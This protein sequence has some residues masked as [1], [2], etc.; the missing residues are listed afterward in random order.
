MKK[1]TKANL[2]RITK[3]KLSELGYIELQD[4]LTGSNGLFGKQIE[5]DFFLTLGLE[6]SRY[7]HS[8]FT[9]SFYLSKTTRWG[10]VWGDIPQECYE[11]VGH[12]LT[13]E[14][15]KK[16]LSEEFQKE[17]ILDAWCDAA[18]EK[19]VANFIEVV[20][21]SEERFVR[22]KDLP[23]KIESSREIK[24]LLECA[25]MVI[26]KATI[27][28]VNGRSY[29]FLPTRAIDD[30]PMNWF[31]AAEE[32]LSQRKAILNANTVKLLAA[33]AWRQ[34]KIKEVKVIH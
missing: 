13:P 9:A 11:R 8:M 24:E 23:K 19:E 26:D 15:R 6:I 17:G 34:K 21:V 2:I 29:Q 7:Y 32:V 4:T 27:N 30:I 28:N 14:E 5:K 20:R 1:L 10:S 33:D 25:A 31:R 16:Y 3:K 18:N 22:Q 12:F